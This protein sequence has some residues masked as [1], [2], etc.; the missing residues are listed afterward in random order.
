MGNRHS[1]TT[2]QPTTGNLK[3]TTETEDKVQSGLLLDIVVG[4][5]ASIFKLLTSKDQ[6]LLVWWDPLLVLNL[7]FHI[8]D[9]VRTLHLQGD[10]LP[11]KVFT[12]ICIPP[13]SLSTK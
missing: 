2:R 10:G 8:V 7:S 1:Q 11:V 6:P 5:G 9:G 3:T 12:K 4:K 13:L